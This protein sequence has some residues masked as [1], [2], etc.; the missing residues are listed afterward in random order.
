MRY[1]DALRTVILGLDQLLRNGIEIEPPSYTT[2][3]CGI[4]NAKPW[5][6]GRQLMNAIINVSGGNLLY[7]AHSVTVLSKMKTAFQ[8]HVRC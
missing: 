1:L 4:S 2:G 5:P 6:L 7:H 8:E 3:V